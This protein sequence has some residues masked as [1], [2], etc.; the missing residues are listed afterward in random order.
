MDLCWNMEG[1]IENIHVIPILKQT[2]KHTLHT[3]IYLLWPYT[4]IYYL[5]KFNLI[6]KK[7]PFFFFFS[8]G[9]GNAIFYFLVFQ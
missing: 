6:I 7:F 2:H 8:T 9:I 4:R 5:M 1:K 3:H